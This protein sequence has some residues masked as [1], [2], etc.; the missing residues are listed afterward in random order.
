M[1]PFKKIVQRFQLTS[2]KTARAG[3]SAL[4][5]LTNAKAAHE[6]TNWNGSYHDIHKRCQKNL[7]GRTTLTLS[8]PPNLAKKFFTFSSSQ[9]PGPNISRPPTN[10][11]KGSSSLLDLFMEFSFSPRFLGRIG[12]LPSQLVG[13]IGSW[14][15]GVIG[16]IDD[17]S[18]AGV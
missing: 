9:A 17:A 1:R 16:V 4:L 18:S 2:S 11:V 3:D 12:R 10:N 6:F 7:Q 13:V 15:P 5:N 14:D 8:R